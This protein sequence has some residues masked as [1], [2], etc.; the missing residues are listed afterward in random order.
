MALVEF[1]QALGAADGSLFGIGYFGEG[2]GVVMIA[3]FSCPCGT[4]SA[5]IDTGMQF[6][7]SYGVDGAD[8]ASYRL[9]AQANGMQRL[10]F[11]GLA[12]GD[13]GLVVFEGQ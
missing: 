11:S 3:A 4:D 10:Y 2:L 8:T 7:Y 12:T 13:T 1:T 9:S 5:Y 6:I